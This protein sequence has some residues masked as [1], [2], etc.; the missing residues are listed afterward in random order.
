VGVVENF[1]KPGPHQKHVTQVIVHELP[2]WVIAAHR[3]ARLGKH[4]ARGGRL[5]RF[6]EFDLEHEDLTHLREKH[7][8]LSS[9]S[10]VWLEYYN[11]DVERIA[12]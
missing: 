2:S 4:T 10:K 9:A 3:F 8:G 1:L 11:S 5:N 6:V 12:L 7:L